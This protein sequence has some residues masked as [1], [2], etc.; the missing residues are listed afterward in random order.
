MRA[1]INI[2]LLTELGWACDAGVYKHPAPD[3]A[4]FGVRSSYIHTA[5]DGARLGVRCRH[6]PYYR[7]SRRDSNNHGHGCSIAVGSIAGCPHLPRKATLSMDR[8][9]APPPSV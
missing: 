1:A 6:L 9:T 2:P 8:R 5:P 7:C 4:R 3:G